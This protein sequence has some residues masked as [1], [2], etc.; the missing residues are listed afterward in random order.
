MSRNCE[1]CSLYCWIFIEA[2]LGA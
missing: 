2:W 1:E